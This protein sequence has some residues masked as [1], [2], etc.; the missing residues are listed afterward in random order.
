MRR[1]V[2]GQGRVRIATSGW[3]Y[4]H[5]KDAFYPRGLKQRDRFAYLASRFDTVELNGSF[6][7]L[8]SAAAVARWA[9]SA[10]EGFVYAW[11][12]SRYITQAKKLKDVQASLD[13]VFGRM[14]PLGPHEGPALFQLPPNLHLN[15]DRLTAFLGQLPSGR[16]VA[17]EF[18]HR[19]WYVE[20]VYAA[21][22][23]AGVALC[24]SDHHDAPA[25]WEATAN[26]VYVRGHGPGGAY[27]GRYGPDALDRW[28]ERIAA[29]RD[30]G[31]DVFAYFDN[32]IGAAAPHDALELKARLGQPVADI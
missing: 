4:P 28:A 19:S 6:Y 22:R 12:A 11:K 18:R 13:L 5:W 25:P 15:L 31:R 26:F 16:R 17:V 10:P 1:L 30:Q 20:P 9:E 29:W 32:D 27:H 21:L 14:A 24:I 8:P 3:V 7:R 23:Q 2:D